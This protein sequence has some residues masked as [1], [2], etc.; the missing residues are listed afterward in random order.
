VGLPVKSDKPQLVSEKDVS[1]AAKVVTLGCKLPQRSAVT[2]WDD[3]PSVSDNY[4]DAS[5]AI[6]KHV[7]KLVNELAV[8]PT[9]KKR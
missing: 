3:I 2:D 4:R 6:R 5:A 1:N 9:Q 7:E 8:K